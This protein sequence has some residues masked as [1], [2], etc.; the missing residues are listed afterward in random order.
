MSIGIRRKKW[1]AFG[2]LAHLSECGIFSTRQ[3]GYFK[4]A[5]LENPEM[6]TGPLNPDLSCHSGENEYERHSP[7]VTSSD[8]T[9]VE[10]YGSGHVW[11]PAS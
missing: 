10:L 6:S 7:V 11:Q 4:I 8:K 5:E 2:N 3:D 1:R 9:C